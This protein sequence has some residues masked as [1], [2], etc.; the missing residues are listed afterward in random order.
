[1]KKILFG[2]AAAMLFTAASHVSAMGEQPGQMPLA[3]Y[4]LIH[5]ML[6]REVMDMCMR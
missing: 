2:F 4:C 6:K 3:P 5:G 1:M